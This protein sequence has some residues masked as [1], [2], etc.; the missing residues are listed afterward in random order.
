MMIQK[1][2]FV[3]D[4]Y[5][6]KETHFDDQIIPVNTKHNLWLQKLVPYRPLLTYYQ[7]VQKANNLNNLII[8]SNKAFQA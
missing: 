4:W 8:I 5:K 6:V 1:I 7:I 2:V 3:K